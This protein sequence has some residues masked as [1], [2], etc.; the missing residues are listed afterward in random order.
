M[1]ICGRG[2]QLSCGLG[3]DKTVRFCS[4]GGRLVRP[5]TQLYLSRRYLQLPKYRHAVANEVTTFHKPVPVSSSGQIRM[6]ICG[7][8]HQLSCGFGPDQTV[9]LCLY[10]GRLVRP[11]TQFH[12]LCRYLQLSKYG[13][14]PLTH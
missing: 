9:R 1:L 12:L 3:L 4:Y 5:V 6:L 14:Q 13:L 10:G 11:V 8:G 7:R 2:R